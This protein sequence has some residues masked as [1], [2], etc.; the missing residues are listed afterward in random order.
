MI[1]EVIPVD[2]IMLGQRKGRSQTKNNPKPASR[3]GSPPPG[4]KPP[5][6]KRKY[7]R[8]HTGS[9]V[10]QD[11]QVRVSAAGDPADSKNKRGSKVDRDSIELGMKIRIMSLNIEGMSMP[12]C[13]YI[14]NL[15]KTHNID[16]LLLQETHLK[17]S[18]PPSRYNINGY[19]LI[20]RENHA[21]YG[22]ATYARKPELVS[23]I[24]SITYA[25]NIQRSVDRVGDTNVVN[26]YKPPNSSWPAPPMQ[27]FEHPTVISGDFNSHHQEWGYRNSDE[28][29]EAV[30]EWANQTNLHLIYNPRERGT[31]L[32]AQPT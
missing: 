27:Q 4:P 12:K 21:Q 23:Q 17:D 7:K 3:R 30:H 20:T 28:A 2:S 31:F 10:A 5:T 11:N 1:L 26:I 19:T 8:Y 13:D 18:D 24:E 22:I 16:I 6:M 29:G 14:A 15:L 9:A 25:E 32:S